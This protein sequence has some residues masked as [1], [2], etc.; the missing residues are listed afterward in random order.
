MLRLMFLVSTLLTFARANISN[1][2]SGSEAA[3]KALY[4]DV[5]LFRHKTPRIAALTRQVSSHLSVSL[6]VM[7]QD[8]ANTTTCASRLVPFPVIIQ[9]AFELCLPVGNIC[10]AY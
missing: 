1:E 8:A 7:L 2:F 4:W 5:E 10:I 9:S 3:E 6:P